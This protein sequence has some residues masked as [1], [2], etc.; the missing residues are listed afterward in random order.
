MFGV[1]LAKSV[2]QVHG[3]S[4]NGEILFQRKL[5][6]EAFYTLMARHPA[7]VV[8]MEVCGSAHYWFVC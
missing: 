5:S 2:F 3:T 8:G 1:G 4:M 6:R 7:A